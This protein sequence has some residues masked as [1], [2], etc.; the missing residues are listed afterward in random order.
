MHR[1]YCRIQASSRSLN[2]LGKLLLITVVFTLLFLP[3]NA[4][5]DMNWGNCCMK[6]AREQFNETN[7]LTPWKVC[8]VDPLFDY[9]NPKPNP[10][11]SATL[12]WCKQRCPGYQMSSA[13]QW[14]QPLTTWVI[15]AIALLVLCSV[16]ESRRK[17]KEGESQRE[18]KDGE[19]QREPKEGESQREPEEGESRRKPK[20]GESQREPEEGESR[21]KPED[22]WPFYTVYYRF[23]EYVALLGDPSSAICGAFTELWM[24][25]SMAQD[26]TTTKDSTFAQSVIK[27]AMLA[28]Q[29][30]FCGV[31]KPNDSIRPQL[32]NK[33]EKNHEGDEGRRKI[34]QAAFEKP[35]FVS[36][37]QRAFKIVLKTRVDFV[38]GVILPVVLLLA[39]TGSSFHDAY[40]QL[41]SNDTAHSLAYGIWYSWLIILAVVS[42]SNILSVSPGL[43]KDLLQESLVLGQTVPLRWRVKTTYDW[44]QWA[45][46]TRDRSSLSIL[47]SR[48]ASFYLIYLGGQT[49]SW[50]CVAFVCSCAATISYNTPTVG[51]GCRSFGFLLYGVL[52]IVLSWLMVLRTWIARKNEMKY[53]SRPSKE[54]LIKLSKVL[55]ILYAGIACINAFVLVFSTIGQLV[56]LFRSCLCTHFGALSDLVELSTGTELAIHNAKVTWLPVGFVAFTGV[57]TVCVIAIVF[58]M[59]NSFRMEKLDLVK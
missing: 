32:N 37:V 59:L 24:D 2:G 31:E 44:R 51:I 33:E 23:K 49:V 30:E 19:S 41:G 43:T 40:L 8:G 5:A 46:I 25:A 50:V 48:P 7:L 45:K 35:E 36:Q 38:N 13:E 42:N 10:S 26:L 34:I 17:P 9:K 53:S 28:S 58:R 11:I 55:K 52:A 6:A 12:G 56:G 47:Q 21:R 18:P 20:E 22:R 3:V 39:T 1:K 16:G 27:I 29:T 4:I 54:G 14:L 15:P 57:W